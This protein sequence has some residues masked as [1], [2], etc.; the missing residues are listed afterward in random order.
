MERASS[1]GAGGCSQ[2][3]SVAGDARASSDDDTTDEDGVTSEL[4]PWTL[5][6]ADVSA[7]ET[8]LSQDGIS[9]VVLLVLE[10]GSERG[11]DAAGDEVAEGDIHDGS[12]LVVES[13]SLIEALLADV[14]EEGVVASGSEMTAGAAA[15]T[16]GIVGFG[17]TGAGA[18]EDGASSHP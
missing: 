5:D 15:G 12:A 7:T 4:A 11:V 1:D 18:G 13:G 3:G 17:T 10:S 9:A 16:D 6:S 14:S 2:D 8:G